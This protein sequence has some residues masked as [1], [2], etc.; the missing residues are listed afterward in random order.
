[1]RLARRPDQRLA[2]P[3]AVE[4]PGLELAPGGENRLRGVAQVVD[5]VQRVVDAEDVDAALGRARHEAAREVAADGARADEEAAADR[6]CEWGLRARLQRA[7]PLPRALDAAPHGVVE[8]AAAGDLEVRETGAV[9]DLGEA[10]ELGRR[11]DARKR[12]LAEHADRRVDEPGHELGPYR[13]SRS[14]F[15]GRS[16]TRVRR[17]RR[18]AARARG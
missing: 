8:D 18:R 1:G 12:L 9:E 10:E 17:A 7:D 5:V 6:E 16:R 13:A 2:A 15:R 14:G 3:A 11:H 4:Q